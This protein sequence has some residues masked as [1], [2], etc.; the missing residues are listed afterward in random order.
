MDL[1]FLLLLAIISAVLFGLQIYN[2]IM[3]DRALEKYSECLSKSLNAIVAEIN[4]D[5]LPETGMRGQCYILQK[6]D[7]WL[8]Y[9]HDG[10][11]WVYT[12][13]WCYANNTTEIFTEE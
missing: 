12:N 6:D 4:S 9:I 1:L 13:V 11:D 8:G 2:T 5:T 7:K 10:T 3:L